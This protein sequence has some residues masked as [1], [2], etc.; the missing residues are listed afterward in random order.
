[1]TPK[2]VQEL[3]L[4]DVEAMLAMVLRDQLRCRHTQIDHALR[5]VRSLRTWAPGEY[6]KASK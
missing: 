6:A 3:V 4:Q 5:Y 2:V 1:M